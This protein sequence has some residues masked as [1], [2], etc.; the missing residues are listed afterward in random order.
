MHTAQC[1]AAGGVYSSHGRLHGSA[2]VARHCS[3][4]TSIS[5][6]WHNLT[7]T[8]MDARCISVLFNA[9]A[10]LGYELAKARP[11]PMFSQAVCRKH[12]IDFAANNCF[13]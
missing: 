6:E 2:E 5:M 7:A 13:V 11:Q 4:R 8:A 12:V 1:R 9:E 10:L 3:T